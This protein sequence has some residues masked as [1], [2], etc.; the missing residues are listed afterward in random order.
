MKEN[1][2]I[3]KLKMKKLG[4]WGKHR[5]NRTAQMK[6]YRE[7]YPDKTRAHYAITNHTHYA[8]N[9]MIPSPTCQI[10]GGKTKT[11]AHHSNYNDFLNVI[12]VC[13]KCHNLIHKEVIK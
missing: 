3:Y 11:M 4:L 12:W 6:R 5:G 13:W 8:K 1:Q 7:K 9:R 10:C 2:R